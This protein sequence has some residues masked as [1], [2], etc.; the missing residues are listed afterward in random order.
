LK[1]LNDCCACGEDFASLAA[2]DARSPRL[3]GGA[4]TERPSERM[5]G[6][7]AA[8]V[9]LC[10]KC[11]APVLLSAHS[12]VPPGDL[13]LAGWIDYWAD[14]RRSRRVVAQQVLR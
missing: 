14:L 7:S 5:T 4:D 1:P 6:M 11:D 13:T 2:F 3:R 12:P 8:V 10:W 9:A